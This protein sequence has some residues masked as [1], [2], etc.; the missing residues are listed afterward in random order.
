MARI[1]PAKPKFIDNNVLNFFLEL[2]KS[3][4]DDYLIFQNFP[5]FNSFLVASEGYD[6]A[7]VIIVSDGEYIDFDG[8]TIQRQNNPDLDID[9]LVSEIHSSLSESKIDIRPKIIFF[10]PELKNQSVTEVRS[11]VL[12]TD[13]SFLTKLFN[14]INFIEMKIKD[15]SHPVNGAV[16]DGLINYLSP[17]SSP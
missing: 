7:V 11:S 4:N 10:T 16:L 12:N 8:M 9:I 3:F 5:I 15:V 17:G 6:S 13:I 14:P 2:E 1:V